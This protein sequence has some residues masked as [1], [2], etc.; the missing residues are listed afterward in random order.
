VDADPATLVAEA[1]KTGAVRVVT[2]RSVGGRPQVDVRTV[3]GRAA[4]AEAVAGAQRQADV[5][6][7]AVDTRAHISAQSDDPYRAQQWAL[8][9]LKAEELW[10][11]RSG[12][13]VTVAV[14]D[15]GVAR[16]TDLGSA[17]LAGTDYVTAGD[18]TADGNGHGTHVAGIIGAVAGNKVGIAGYAPGVKILPVR[19]LGDD[20]SGWNSDIAK[21]IVWAADHGA[22]VVNLSLGSTSGDTV[23]GDAVRYALSRNVV[24]VAAAGNSRAQG[25]PTSYPAAF[26]GVI[27]VAATTSKD[28][29]ASYSNAGSYVDVAAPGSGIIS[30]YPGNQYANL[31]GTSMASPYVAAAAAV[32][33]AAKPSLTPA[34]VTTALQS[35]ALDLGPQ[36]R[37]NDFG[38]GLI[39]PN[40]A[41][42][43]V[44]SCTTA[45]PVPTATPAPAATPSPTTTPAPERIAT[46]TRML[47]R[48]AVVAYGSPI[49]GLAR[50]TDAR[51]NGLARVPAQL[52][53][54]V[55]PATRYTCQSRTTDSRGELSYRLTARARTAVY[56]AHP[57]T[58]RTAPSVAPS[59]VGYS[60][61]PRISLRAG[62]NT[63]TASVGT[64]A[65]Q[66][67]YLDRWTGR[68]WVQARA[69]TVRPGGTVTFRGLGSA[70][71]RVRVP[72]TPTLVGKTTNHV[73]VR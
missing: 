47:S 3:A 10:G 73:R 30:T 48:P 31:S 54:R 17:L 40:A 64:Q 39:D 59:A 21:G 8:T 38:H 9:R 45:T 49:T 6:S 52:C 61:T 71:Y 51:G 14:V 19:V 15:S 46:V 69:A 58:E 36:G 23:T 1:P 29:V 43:T 68:T 65:R 25:S 18:G 16:H 27:G 5:V 50:I 67:V 24:V 41:L 2:V 11:R 4:A 35:T 66:R 72:A 37:D 60:V 57:G 22:A 13:A 20:G 55:H 44:A 70:Y 33:K 56:A 63:V 7:V 12:A 62:R 53:L 42:C 28:A 32:L 34:E 26:P